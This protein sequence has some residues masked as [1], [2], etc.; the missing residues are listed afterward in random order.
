MIPACARPGLLISLGPRYNLFS[1][2]DQLK[3]DS[4]GPGLFICA[5][6]C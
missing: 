3:V 4:I 1:C 2:A 6:I 5:R